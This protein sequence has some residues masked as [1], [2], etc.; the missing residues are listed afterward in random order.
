MWMNSGP[1]RTAIGKPEDRIIP[2]LCFSAGDH[3]PISPSGVALQSVERSRSPASPKTPKSSGQSA[4][5]PSPICSSHPIVILLSQFSS[6]GGRLPAVS[7]VRNR[8]RRTGLPLLKTSLGG[9]GSLSAPCWRQ[10]RRGPVVEHLGDQSVFHPGIGHVAQEGDEVVPR[11][12]DLGE[13]RDEGD[14]RADFGLPLPCTNHPPTNRM[15]T[16]P[17]W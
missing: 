7:A 2:T 3:S 14:D 4:L 5:I 8:V 11:V 10:P 9:H 13:A 6:T 15:P 12:V 1:Q 16:V 17:R